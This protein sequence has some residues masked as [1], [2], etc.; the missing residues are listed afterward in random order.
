MARC[1][2]TA[3]VV[4]AAFP[5]FRRRAALIAA[6]RQR[7][8]VEHATLRAA[9]AA[10][11]AAAVG[12]AATALAERDRLRRAAASERLAM[13]AEE[14]ASV[15]REAADAAVAV[16]RHDYEAAAYAPFIPYCE[17]DADTEL[18]LLPT[19]SLRRRLPLP[20]R[21][22]P[23]AP[24]AGDAAAA[25]LAASATSA[26][27]PPAGGAGAAA[28]VATTSSAASLL[29][30]SASALAVRAALGLD[31][32]PS[33]S[34]LV[35]AIVRVPP[36]P[37]RLAAQAVANRT[38][39]PAAYTAELSETFRMAADMPTLHG[40]GTGRADLART[41]SPPR[42]HRSP[43]LPQH[44]TA[45]SG[46]DAMR[47]PARAVPRAA[48]ATVRSPVTATASGSHDGTPPRLRLGVLGTPVLP[49][50]LP[51]ALAPLSGGGGGS[52]ATG[53]GGGMHTA[54]SS[55]VLATT[56]RAVAA[57]AATGNPAALRSALAGSNPVLPRRLPGADTV[58]GE[59]GGGV[60]VPAHSSPVDAALRRA[61]EA[62][63]AAGV[64]A[65]RHSVTS[66][67]ARAAPPPSP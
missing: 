8:E 46:G 38:P 5:A 2:R 6:A 12:V 41:P 45:A 26:L 56:R 7:L 58:K 35:E 37:E 42:A 18:H 67:F 1:R 49:M 29:G 61:A 66:P 13:A 9:K 25:T 47:T 17:P 53:S 24:S 11:A 34:A 39:R 55:A 50:S 36:S 59:R 33:I 27:L 22:R 48:A 57:A 30:G 44:G 43:P 14:R 60:V 52:G 51:A 19:S 64:L 10:T 15:A 28:A 23:L 31:T 21:R 20:A 16:A 54:A 65:A 63:A 62:V 40:Y 4:A 3:A 32:E